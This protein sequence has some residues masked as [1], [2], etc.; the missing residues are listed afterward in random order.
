MNAWEITF[1][2]KKVSLYFGTLFSVLEYI[3][4]EGNYT[5]DDIVK[6]ELK[7]IETT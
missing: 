6:I 3:L 4:I 1:I 7:H 5:T 2:D